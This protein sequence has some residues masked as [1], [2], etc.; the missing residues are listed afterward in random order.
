LGNIRSIG[1]GTLMRFAASLP[2]SLGNEQGL[3]QAAMDQVQEERGVQ[4][5]GYEHQGSLLGFVQFSVE[6]DNLLPADVYTLIGILVVHPAYRRLGIGLALVRAVK[7]LAGTEWIVASPAD[8][9]AERFFA[10]CGFVPL[11]H[12]GEQPEWL[13]AWQRSRPKPA[14]PRHE[15]LREINWNGTVVATE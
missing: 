2:S 14:T 4:T 6:R 3:V 8:G 10:C 12:A 5:L 15:G 7:R 13:M 1:R 9:A 11:H